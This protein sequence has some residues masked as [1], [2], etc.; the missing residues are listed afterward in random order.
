MK[1]TSTLAAIVVLGMGAA[2]AAQRG[3]PPLPNPGEIR[4]PPIEK[5]Q[6]VKENLYVIPGA[7]GNTAVFVTAAGV[8]LVD[9]KVPN[10]GQAILEQVRSVTNRPVTTIINT[11]S[12]FDHVGSNEAFAAS[13]DVIAHENTRDNM[14]KMAEVKSAANAMPDRTYKDRLTIGRGADQVDLYHFGPGHTNGDTFVVFPALRTVHT[15]DL[16]AEKQPPLLDR[17]NGGS[18][19]AYP[20]TLEKAVKG[21][22]NVDTVIPGHSAVMKWAD[23]VEYA[24]FNREFLKAVENLHHAGRTPEQA[25][26]ELRLPAKFNAYVSAT[27][28]APG[29][30]FLGSG[31]QRA[32]G[33]VAT[34]MAELN[35]P[36]R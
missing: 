6:K 15:G 29:L 13:V 33:N 35:A 1:R 8:V 14:A 23:L 31:Q 20:D 32:R 5:I 16:F 11:H 18:G 3:A 34:I 19:V 2:L 7:G 21:I 12:H 9:T 17:A 28:P 30:E 25:G 27:P 4:L 22:P 10:N 26:A 24:E 36:G